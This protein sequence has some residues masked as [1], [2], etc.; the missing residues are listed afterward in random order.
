MNSQARNHTGQSRKAQ[1][2]LRTIALCCRGFSQLSQ[3]DGLSPVKISAW[4]TTGVL[5]PRVPP[6]I[7]LYAGPLDHW[8]LAEG[9]QCKEENCRPDRCLAPISGLGVA[10]GGGFVATQGA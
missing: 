3:Q 6:F 2:E 5:A 10:K 7:G 4:R 9:C 1:E 8:A